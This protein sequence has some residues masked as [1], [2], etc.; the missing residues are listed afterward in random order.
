MV[1]ALGL[2]DLIYILVIVSGGVAYVVTNKNK[3][4][5]NEQKLKEIMEANRETIKRIEENHAREIDL[6]SEKLNSKKKI[7]D[8]FK[9]QMNKE[10]DELKKCTNKC[11]DNEKAEAKFVTK[12]ELKLLLDNVYLKLDT[13]NSKM[14]DILSFI[15][16]N[17]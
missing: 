10:I 3:T 16:D 1:E 9:Q 4:T 8:E 5:T 2:K 17:K 13:L 11:L 15:K 14:D 6:V 12:T 7:F